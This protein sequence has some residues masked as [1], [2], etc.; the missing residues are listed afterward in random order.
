MLQPSDSDTIAAIATAPGA[1]AI[2]IVRLSGPDAIAIADQVFRPS[3]SHLPSDRSANTFVHGFVVD[4][5]GVAVDDVLMLL[6]R[7]PHSYT[8]ENTVELQGHGGAVATRR[9]LRVVLDAGARA[10]QPGEFTKRAFLNGRLD[11]V[12]AEAVLDL[13]C[14]RSDAAASAAREQLDG[15]LSRSLVELYDGAMDV[16]ADLEATLDFV[17]HE[18]PGLFRVHEEPDPEALR[19]FAEF[20][21]EF[22]ISLRPPFDRHKLKSVLER[23]AGKDFAHAVHLGLLTSLKQARY[24]PVCQPHFALNFARYLHFTSP[25]RRYPDLVVHRALDSR[26]EPG[27]AALPVHGKK[28]PG[29][30]E[31]REYQ[32]RSDLLRPLAAHCSQRER[33]A[34]VAETE[35]IKFRQMQFLRR[36]LKESHPGLITGVRDFGLFVQLQDCFVEGL[37]RVQELTDDWYEYFEDQHLLQGRRRHRSFR[38]GDKIAVRVLDMNLAQ[39]QVYLEIV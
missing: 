27:Q 11:L 3:T 15:V 10:A 4:A 5:A 33:D 1:A 14:A 21:R 8:G 20:V 12:Q 7:A 36:N 6:F 2:G 39:K 30:Q 17:E 31:G 29:G 13:I 23:V 35:V 18:L 28:R 26:F 22:G 16:A 24:A 34:A 37:V 32:E 9:V 25:I 19:R 38:L